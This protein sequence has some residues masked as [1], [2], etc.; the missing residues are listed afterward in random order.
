MRLQKLAG[1]NNNSAAPNIAAAWPP[2]L[3]H[4]FGDL[5]LK[6][7]RCAS[8]Q[9]FYTFLQF[10]KLCGEIEEGGEEARPEIMHAT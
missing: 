3:A 5:L 8:A 1:I 7:S 6:D 4:S 2:S 10:H 9:K